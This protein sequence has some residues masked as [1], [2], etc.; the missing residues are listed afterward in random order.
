MRKLLLSL[1]VTLTIIFAVPQTANAGM[2]APT[3]G[4]NVTYYNCSGPYYIYGAWRYKCWGDYN[5]WA[6]VFEGQYDRWVWPYAWYT[7]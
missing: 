4:H 2:V 3:H 7:A 6:E 5:W 1:A